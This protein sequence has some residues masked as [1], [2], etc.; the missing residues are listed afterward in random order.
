MAC[1]RSVLQ[2]VVMQ[3]AVIV[4]QFPVF[5]CTVVQYGVGLTL[6]IAIYKIIQKLHI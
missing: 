4:T 1:K 3:D 5:T 6:K 2:V